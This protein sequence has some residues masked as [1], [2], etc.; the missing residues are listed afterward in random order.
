MLRTKFAVLTQLAIEG[1]VVNH[2]PFDCDHM[3]GGG[4]IHFRPSPLNENRIV[5]DV[6]VLPVDLELGREWL[7]HYYENHVA[8][9]RSHRTNK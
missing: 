8:P 6:E 3:Y 7:R 1:Q 9:T 4:V 5:G 2:N